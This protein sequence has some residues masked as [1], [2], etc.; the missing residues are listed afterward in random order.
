QFCP[1][2]VRNPSENPPHRRTSLVTTSRRV[3][4]LGLRARCAI[5]PDGGTSCVGSAANRRVVQ[6][7]GRACCPVLLTVRMV[8]G[9]RRSAPW[10]IYAD[11]AA[12]LLHTRPRRPLRA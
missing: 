2:H 9:Q 3:I 7:C 12:L 6:R 11:R 4:W 10:P 1:H 8:R 5:L